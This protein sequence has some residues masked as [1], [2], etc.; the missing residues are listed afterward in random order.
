[1][2]VITVLH[3]SYANGLMRALAET[4]HDSVEALLSNVSTSALLKEG[5]SVPKQR[6]RQLILFARG[7]GLIEP[8]DPL[9]LTPAGNEYVQA[10]DPEDV[11][12]ITEEQAA[13]L[14]HLM[15]TANVPNGYWDGVALAL[16]LLASAPQPPAFIAEEF[17][18]A[19]A[20]V[21]GMDSWLSKNTF[22]TQGRH[23]MALLRDAGLIDEHRKLIEAGVELLKQL[24]VPAHEDFHTALHESND[25]APT[26]TPPEPPPS[27][28]VWVIRAG[29]KGEREAVALAEGVSLIGWE[30][31]G[32]LSAKPDRDWLKAKVAEQ[33]SEHNFTKKSIESQ[34]GQ[35]WRFVHEVAVGD[36]VV[37]PLKTR[38]RHVAVGRV[39]GDYSY[40]PD[41]PFN[42]DSCHTRD[43]EWLDTDAPYELFDEELI[44]SFGAQGTVSA[45]S[46]DDAPK[47]L[48]EGLQ[49][50]RPALHLVLKWSPSIRADTIDLHREVAQAHGAVW[51]GR[52]SKA[53]VTGLG[54]NWIQAL[55]DQISRQITTYVFL[56]SSAGGTWRT[57]LLD[58]TADS[59]DVE[60][61][62][63]PAHYDPATHHSLWVKLAAF[64]KVDE[65][66]ILDN[67]V[68][69]ADG[70]PVGLGALHNQTPVILQDK[71]QAPPTTGGTT[72][73]FSVTS[74]EARAAAKKVQ[75][76][77][78]VYKQVWSALESGKHIIFTGPPGTA[79]TTLAMLVADAARAA[80]RCNGY[81]LT[82]ATSDWT[83][84][85]TIGGLRP[86]PD[87][88][89]V[90]EEGL[91]LSAIRSNQWLVIDELNRSNFDR[92]FG[93]L[94]TVLS[95]QPVVLPYTRPGQNGK[96]LV[97]V[98]DE[99][100]SPLPDSEADVLPIP[101][102]WRIIATMNVFDKSLLFEMSFAL[103]RRFA[104]IE[105]P[106]PE[107]AMFEAILDSKTADAEA[108]SEAK[109]MLPLRHVVEGKD[110]G[111]AVFIDI[112][113]YFEQRRTTP[114]A[115]DA[116]TLR[117]EAFYS[118]LLPQFEGVSDEEG[119]RLY[120]ALVAL[121]GNGWRLQIR[122]TLNT[123]LGLQLAP[124]NQPQAAE[125][126]DDDEDDAVVVEDADEAE[127]SDEP[128]APAPSA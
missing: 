71:T 106:S 5:S 49:R 47:R 76:P 55:L 89:L 108:A 34:A 14:R 2:R 63:V 93:Q 38:P 80:Q 117:F 95:G 81:V 70:E 110:I 85:E 51:W 66:H 74:I 46:A 121:L 124:P 102:D 24:D 109:A 3:I 88:S 39:N 9:R 99:A 50:P 83:T 84:Y 28:R 65:Q 60:A 15:L 96:P 123:V 4:S 52:V 112:A 45:L 69:A 31:L 97:L 101:G 64:E 120:K 118:Y 32:D 53:G 27:N 21:G 100:V 125:E 17:G 87:S 42:N 8:D 29:G 61:D 6:L 68:K 16:S 72:S 40:R 7:L 91:F 126:D 113:R 115:V 107:P 114:G 128:E 105:I 92:A 56:T 19:L 82:T 67:Y 62:L 11:W 86:Q 98:P 122:R 44:A 37:L 23:Y 111:P 36:L 75:L 25:P 58:I 18:R 59:D 33:Y 41:P 103:M 57:E 116:S 30:R 43:T 119:E 104:F 35:V 78:D 1:M 20:R 13:L 26:P 79:K 12:R 48:L 10:G 127:E 22:I 90:F 77:E 73:T 54:D 94:F